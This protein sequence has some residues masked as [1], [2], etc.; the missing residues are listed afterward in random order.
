MRFLL[1]WGC[2]GSLLLGGCALVSGLDQLSA[3]GDGGALD[4]QVQDSP[5]PGKDAGTDGTAPSDSGTDAKPADTGAP[6]DVA[7]DAP[8]AVT[9]PSGTTCNA[10]TFC[11]IPQGP[12]C[13]AGASFNGGSGSVNGTVCTASAGPKVQTTCASPINS[14][15]T[16][17]NFSSGGNPWNVTIT[18]NNGPIQVQLMNSTCATPGACTAL[19][20]GASTTVVANQGSVVAIVSV[21][22][23][24][25]D[26][27]ATYVSK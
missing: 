7:V 9:C 14:P 19:A 27:Q 12:A 23:G 13:G 6:K 18:A 2:F 1:A 22:N 16:F 26:W 20:P 17:I 4:A 8:C 11:A 25:S 5:N 15:A 21:G 10:G 3:P 24:C